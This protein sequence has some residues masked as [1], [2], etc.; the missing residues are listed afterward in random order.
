[1]GWK[2]AYAVRMSGLQG[3]TKTDVLEA[4]AAMLNETTGECFPSTAT[5]ARVARVSAN[6]V[7]PTLKQLEEEGLIKTSQKPGC[8][9]NFVL[10]LERLPEPFLKQE[11]G[12]DS[13]PL[14]KPEGVTK[15]EGDPSRKREYPPHETVRGPLTRPVAEQGKEL[16]KELER[17]QGV[18]ALQFGDDQSSLFGEAEQP[19]PA[20]RSSKFFPCEYEKLA[21][22]Y[23]EKLPMLPQINTLTTARK[24]AMK[25]RW[26]QVIREQDPE[27]VSTPEKVLETFGFIFDLIAG[28]KFLTGQVDPGAGHSRPF[29]ANFDWIFK[30]SNF[31]KIC[32]RRY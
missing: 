16:G 1:M 14:T 11:G 9:R 12:T 3:K 29:R 24:A 31:V 13:V 25:A 20:P 27:D 15:P 10:F 4:L 23:R 32:E 6:F 30:E 2:S 17:E 8:R 22:L 5:I 19:A 26:M 21:A 7:R 18:G 28:S